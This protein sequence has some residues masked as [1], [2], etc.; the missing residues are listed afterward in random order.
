VNALLRCYACHQPAAHR[1]HDFNMCT[2]HYIE[3]LEHSAHIVSLTREEWERPLKEIARLRVLRL[4]ERIAQRCGEKKAR[5]ELTGRPEGNVPVDS[6][7][8]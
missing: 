7:M 6:R 2:D 4:A 1:L 3:A 8:Q 5:E